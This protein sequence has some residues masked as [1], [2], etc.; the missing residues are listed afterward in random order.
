MCRREDEDKDPPISL[1]ACE[2]RNGKHVGSGTPMTARH[3]SGTGDDRMLLVAIG[4]HAARPPL[5][6]I[7]RRAHIGHDYAHIG[8]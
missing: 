3:L 1:I 8:C 7:D 5:R 6:L 2:E 4:V